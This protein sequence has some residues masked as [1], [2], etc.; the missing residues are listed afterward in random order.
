[1]VLNPVKASIFIISIFLLLT[2][3]LLMINQTD[4]ASAG[5]NVP[6]PK[7]LAQSSAAVIDGNIYIFGGQNANETH[8]K[9]MLLDPT[10]DTIETLNVTLPYPL[11]NPTVF[12][13]GSRAYILGGE[14]GIS[15]NG[16]VCYPE[17]S[18]NLTIFTPPNIINTF[19]DFFPYG[20]EGNAVAYDGRYFLLF[21]NCMCSTEDV[22]RNVIRF[23]PLE[24]EFDIIKNVLPL[25]LSGASAVWYNEAA[26]IFG[27]KSDKGKILDTIIRYDRQGECVM[28]D[29]H[30]PEPVYKMGAARRGPQVYILGG[31]TPRGLSDQFLR[32]DLDEQTVQRTGFYLCQ[33]RASRAVVTIG[34]NVYLIGGD[35]VTGAAEN[36]EIVILPEMSEN[37]REIEEN[38]GDIVLTAGIIGSI[39]ML[40]AVAA[41]YVMDYRRYRKE[42]NEKK[43]KK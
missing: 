3:L 20:L 11:N 17:R 36:M 38:S 23:D 8:D 13:D 22:R 9:I 32:I 41:I 29:I 42:T 40:S 15:G 10:E 16:T 43:E 34:D 31:I 24:L 26:Y 1:M 30:L 4:N 39:I 35:T 33:P 18:R 7:P 19:P 27:G 28:L 2:S 21:G 14:Q 12:S 6:L 37:T 25:N 5:R